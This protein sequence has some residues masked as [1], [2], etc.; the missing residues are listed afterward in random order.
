MLSGLSFPFSLLRNDN[1][2]DKVDDQHIC[3]GR[4][5]RPK[6]SSSQ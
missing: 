5:G 6:R 2:N 1:D 4:S 3:G